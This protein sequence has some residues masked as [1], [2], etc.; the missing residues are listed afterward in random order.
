MVVMGS[1]RRSVLVGLLVALAGCGGG[2]AEGTDATG[3]SSDLGGREASGSGGEGT[4][5]DLVAA[6]T[7]QFEA[8]LTRDD[9]AYFDL[10]SKTCR[11][12]LGFAAVAGHLDGRHFR[13]GL[14]GVDMTALSVADVIVD[15]GGSTATVRLDIDGPSGDQFRETL[16]H[17]WV[18]EDGGWR[19]DDCA[20]FREAQGGLEG[21]GMDRNDP[22]P[23]GGV[24]DIN[25]WLVALVHIAADDEAFIVETGGSPAGDGNQLFVAGVTVSYN[26][27]DPSIVYGEELGFAMV[28]GD[29]IYGDEVDCVG[30]ENDLY[31]DPDT[32]VGPG[33]SVGRPYICR[34]V[35]TDRAGEIL[36][37]VTHLA[38]GDEWWFSLNE[39]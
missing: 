39:S 6:A 29:T 34:E 25:G 16:P 7:T 27:G 4:T 36:L 19:M 35:P 10:L 30:P 2:D 8:F 17:A 14:D 28:A 15:G 18:Y 38:T 37:R 9:E 1:K 26:G 31:V 20:D 24:A 3:A 12:R 11:D 22:L 21:V 5:E 23:F 33:E 32:T 13:A